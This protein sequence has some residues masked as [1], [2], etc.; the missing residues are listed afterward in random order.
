VSDSINITLHLF[1]RC[2]SLFFHGLYGDSSETYVVPGLAITEVVRL[3][4]NSGKLLQKNEVINHFINHLYAP[5]LLEDCGLDNLGKGGESLNDLLPPLL[6]RKRIEEKMKDY[7]IIDLPT[8]LDLI[9]KGCYDGECKNIN[10]IQI[11]EIYPKLSPFAINHLSPER[12][13]LLLRNPFENVESV[14]NWGLFRPN[15]YKNLLKVYQSILGM[16]LICR[17]PDYLKNSIVIELERFKI[18]E[19]YRLSASKMLGFSASDRSSYFG[20]DYI[21]PPSNRSIV[22]KGFVSQDRRA[23][24]YV[25]EGADLRMINCL[26]SPI[27]TYSSYN[28][29]ELNSILP[30]DLMPFENQFISAMDPGEQDKIA[31]VAKE[32]R[33]MAKKII[34]ESTFSHSAVHRLFRVD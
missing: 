6:L 28:P 10:F 9:H 1:G 16:T 27:F 30:Q 19:S 8:S 21:G 34:E 18:E 5:R 22:A 25:C 29:M 24:A 33:L 2:G 15:A 4:S 20:Y 26:M 3:F 14:I 31:R 32:F 13:I 12:K 23:T 17:I 11:H 7:E